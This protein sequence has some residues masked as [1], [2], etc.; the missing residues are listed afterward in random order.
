[1]AVSAA[2]VGLNILQDMNEPVFEMKFECLP[3]ASK[4][5]YRFVLAEICSVSILNTVK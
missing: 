3:P 1:M 2:G 5:G 4:I